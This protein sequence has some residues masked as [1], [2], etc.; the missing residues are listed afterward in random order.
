M[1]KSCEV[2]GISFADRT[3]LKAHHKAVHVIKAFRPVEPV[4]IGDGSSG[5]RG[6][7]TVMP[8]KTTDRTLDQITEALEDQLGIHNFHGYTIYPL[9]DVKLVKVTPDEK[10]ENAYV[11]FFKHLGEFSYEKELMGR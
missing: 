11:N 10:F 5:L 8:S 7:Q 9:E 6:T 3:S 1:V 2:C 4:V